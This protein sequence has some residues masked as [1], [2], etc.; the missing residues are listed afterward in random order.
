M[1]NALIEQ[2]IREYLNVRHLGFIIF[3]S[4]RPQK[5]ISLMSRQGI[6]YPGVRMTSVPPQELA[7]DLAEEAFA[8]KEIME[9][10]IETL[11][12]VN[13]E[14]L[15]EISQMTQEKIKVSVLDPGKVYFH[16]RIG[17]LIWALLCDC[18]LDVNRLI[19]RFLQ[20]IAR[21]V[22]KEEDFAKE[23]EKQ[24]QGIDSILSSQKGL[25]KI[26]QAISLFK[27]ELDKEKE[28]TVELRRENKRLE[29]KN[30]VQQK[31]I[32]ELRKACGEF[33]QEKGLWHKQILKKE[34]EIDSLHQQIG[35]LKNQLVVGPKMRLKSQIHHLEKEN[36]SINYTLE[37]ERR[38]H[39]TKVAEIEKELWQLKRNTEELQ[40]ANLRLHQQIEEEREKFQELQ[41][42]HQL[43][44]NKQEPRPVTIPKEK[45]KRLGV[46]IDN[47]NVYYSAKRYYG[48]KIDYRKFLDV[49]VRDRHLVKAICYVVQHPEVNQNAFLTMLRNNN[50]VVRTR[51][52]IM[53]ADGSAKGNWDIGIAADVMTMVRENSLDIV[54]L[55]TCDGD[56]VD[57]IKLLSVNGVKVEVIGFPMN[58]A[59]DLKKEADDYYFITEDLMGKNIKTVSEYPLATQ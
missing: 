56:F 19:P 21:I 6:D 55:V 28:M 31:L 40:Q 22:R 13:S 25:K 30:I 35:E 10:V 43:I 50:Y 24:T 57:L 29:E 32:Q 7:C 36:S 2:K 27:K 5:L 34:K 51:D 14:M 15:L 42:T 41:K 9:V 44:I 26:N 53:R 18:R 46:F 38:E 49:V 12:E 17:R 33:T 4:L 20:V 11:N 59:V 58:M 37:K 39:S 3:D 1:E 45:G 48:K 54:A 16:E 52:L 23:M 47:Q 8:H